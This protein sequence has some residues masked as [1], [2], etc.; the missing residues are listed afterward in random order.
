M[1][2]TLTTKR[3]DMVLRLKRREELER[4][5]KLSSLEAMLRDFERV[6]LDLEQQIAAEE[7][8]TEIT[9]PAHCAY[10]TSATAGRL[11]QSKLSITIADL[12]ERLGSARREHEAMTI[13]L[14]ELEP[15]SSANSG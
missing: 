15:L 14:R 2:G 3:R 10:S 9:D 8:R 13:E 4:S 11:R 6:A 12:R 1:H 7:A 5:L